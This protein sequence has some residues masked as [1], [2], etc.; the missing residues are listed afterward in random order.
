[1]TI[2]GDRLKRDR[3][4]WGLSV[5]QAAWWY[6]VSPSV[7]RELEAGTRWPSSDKYERICDLFG[8]P[9]AFFGPSGR[10]VYK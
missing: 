9:Q 5:G 3:E 4:R 2:F 10:A 8:W 7:Y 1:V 6:G